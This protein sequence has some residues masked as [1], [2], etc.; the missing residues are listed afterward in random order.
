VSAAQI[1]GNRLGIDLGGTKIEAI[2]MDLKG[3]IVQ[4]ERT[5]TPNDYQSIL[6]A[7]S[8]I[9]DQLT[10]DDQ[11]PLGIGTPGAIS[12]LTGLMK[13]CN[14]T[15]LN[16]QPLPQALET[17]LGRKV[18]IANDADCFTLSEASDGATA[19]SSSVFGVI[20]GT[21][22]GGGICINQKL[23]SGV[24]AICGEWGHNTLALQAYQGDM[25]PTP[26]RL[27]YCGRYDCVETWLSG[28]GLE[29][30]Y[31]DQTG[32]SLKAQDIVKLA[33]K[34]DEAATD[35]LEQ[36]YN[37]LALALS[38]V[39]NILDPESIVLGG[40]ISNIKTIYSEVNRYLPRY[41]FTDQFNNKIV[42]AIHGDSSGVRGAAWLW[43]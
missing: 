7:I 2:V 41:V 4:R 3:D 13:N 20:L 25:A 18:K 10:I 29:K 31:V 39:I 11:T 17:K 8:G 40:G 42:P 36:Y 30:S 43:P 16:G 26:G 15:C 23:L 37:L 27:C 19:G 14:S 35:I 9:V 33:E 6:N 21:G 34:S 38:V 22:V 32:Q 12:L 28:P 1:S 5:A 24:S